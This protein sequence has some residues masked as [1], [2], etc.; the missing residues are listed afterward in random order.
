MSIVLVHGHPETAEIWDP[1]IAALGSSDVVT[2]QLP[3]YGS[4]R[5]PGFDATKESYVDW[6]IQ[7]L[8]KFDDPVDLVGHDVGGAL[9]IRVAT[10]RSELLRSWT[11]DA[12]YLFDP[13][14]E[15]HRFAK[16]WQTAGDGERDV[17]LSLSTPAAVRAPAFERLGVPGPWAE[18]VAGWF[19]QTMADCTLDFF[20]SAIDITAEWGPQVERI[21]A[22]GVG[23]LAPEDVFASE[24]MSRRVAARA[25]ATTVTLSGLGHWWMLQ[26]PGAAVK[27]LEPRWN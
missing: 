27:A 15:W 20:R 3:G 9:A 7:T 10:L 6:L 18:R 5:P 4:Q 13:D 1:F 25:K 2:L 14:Y 24:E 23:I 19:D 17:Q 11:S 12:L 21:T 8:E 16:T 26:S 22:P